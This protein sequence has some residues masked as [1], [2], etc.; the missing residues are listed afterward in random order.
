MAAITPPPAQSDLLALPFDQYSRQFIVAHLINT[1][2]RPDKKATLKLIDLGGHK[3]KTHEFLPAD[4]VTIL[5]VFDESYPNY[6]KGDATNM[7]FADNEFDIATSF[8]V[9]EHIPRDKRQ[10]FVNEALRVSKIGVFIAMPIE[11]GGA[12]SA[13]EELLND[14]H[15]DLYQQ[16]HSWL[17]EHIDY[18]IPTPAELDALI[19]KS[20]AK[21]VSLASNQVTDWAL[22]QTL[23]FAAARNPYVTDAVTHLNRWYNQHIAQLELGVDVGYRRI[24]FITKNEQLLGQVKKAVALMTSAEGK[25][26]HRYLKVHESTLAEALRTVSAMGKAFNAE[27]HARNEQQQA[28]NRHVTELEAQNNQLKAE[29]ANIRGSL[30]WRITQPIR[31]IKKRLRG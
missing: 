27:V 5:D 17:K 24:Y 21:A 20:G 12:V 3:G 11:A 9:F 18:R 15:K 22:L 31:S 1:A 29:I 30:S 10:A 28:L 8:D 19:A 7:T 26:N 14:I 25:E 23:I 2:L 4:T 16:D 6:V 13:A